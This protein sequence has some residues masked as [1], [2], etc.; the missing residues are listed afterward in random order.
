M[1][2][3][4]DW[5]RLLE[6]ARA[7]VTRTIEDLPRD[8]QPR[9]AALPV[10]FE[11]VPNQAILADGFEPDLLGL[12][13]GGD[14]VHESDV[15]LPA[16]IILFLENIWEMVEGDEEDFI[17]EVHVT[18][19]HELGHYLGLDEDDLDERGLL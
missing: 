13:V 11:R 7:E 19:V 6:V 14:F 18:Y 8:L 9:A 2:Q 1:S 16:Q 17:E 15:P 4:I 5:P 3:P 12:F 10:T